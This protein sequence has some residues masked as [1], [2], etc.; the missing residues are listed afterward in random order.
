MDSL[1]ATDI[2]VYDSHNY[3][4]AWIN[5]S[6]ATG[7]MGYNDF[8]YSNTINCC[9]AASGERYYAIVGYKAED[10]TGYDTTS[11]LTNYAP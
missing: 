5:S 7:L 4:V 3:C 6:N 1:G 11:Y 8:Y 10:S 9:S 2:F